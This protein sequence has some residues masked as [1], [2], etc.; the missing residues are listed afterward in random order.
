MLAHLFLFEEGKRCYGNETGWRM[1]ENTLY[2]WQR[3]SDAACVVG[4]G[5]S[6]FEVFT[7]I[8]KFIYC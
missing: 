3:V 7:P 6:H 5:F 1:D 2:Q 4:F 8:H